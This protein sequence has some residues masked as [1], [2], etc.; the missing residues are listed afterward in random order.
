MPEQQVIEQARTC[1]ENLA[2][3]AAKYRKHDLAELVYVLDFD[4]GC[5]L[6]C[7]DAAIDYLESGQPHKAR[8]VIVTAYN[9]HT[10]QRGERHR[11]WKIPQ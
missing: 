5:L 11:Y 3:L 10:R 6:G 2:R 7:M 1:E 8:E 9:N 4:L